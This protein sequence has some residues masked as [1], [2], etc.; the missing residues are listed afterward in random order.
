ME[1]AVERRSAITR[2]REAAAYPRHA[3]PYAKEALNI[4]GTSLP[5]YSGL[6][7]RL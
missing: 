3:G 5:H 2:D 6:R 1:P 4:V 7:A